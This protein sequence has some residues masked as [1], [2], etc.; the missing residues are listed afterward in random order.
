MAKMTDELTSRLPLFAV[1]RGLEVD[2]AA[3]VGRVLIAA[4]FEILEVTMNSPAPLESIAAI[5]RA[6]GPGALVGAGTVTSVE[7]VDA[8]VDAGGRLVVS[9]HCDPE[10]I[11]YAAKRQLVVLPGVLSPSEIFAAI[12]AGASGVKI[13]PAEI[14]P[15]AGI[16]AVK[17]VLPPDVPVYVV[18]GIHADNM[19]SYL[20]AGAAGFGI[21]GS[22]FRPGKS[23]S[24]IE[25][26]AVAIVAQFR[27]ART[28]SA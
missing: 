3:D 8:V 10:L 5:A 25:R 15:P 21:G 22:L 20:A 16:K 4:G 7:E 19:G 27:N 11:A 6:V 13:F 26:D 14:M 1:L 12:R 17:A 28:P 24:D 2:R 9:P 18:G 23:L